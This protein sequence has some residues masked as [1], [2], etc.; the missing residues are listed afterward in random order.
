MA[1]VENNSHFRIATLEDFLIKLG[2]YMKSMTVSY[3]A[4]SGAWTNRGL[5][6]G[7]DSSRIQG[8]CNDNQRGV[9]KHGSRITSKIAVKVQEKYENLIPGSWTRSL[10]MLHASNPLILHI[11]AMVT[12]DRKCLH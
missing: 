5:E 8:H 6:F 1:R 10:R 11:C 7:Q 3:N 4:H 9:R 12:E 2:K